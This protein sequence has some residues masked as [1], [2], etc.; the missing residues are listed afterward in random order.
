MTLPPLRLKKNEDRRLRAGHLW[1]FSNEVDTGKTPLTAFEAGQLIEIQ[2]CR[3]EVIG[4]GYVNPHSLICARLVSRDP[5]RVLNKSLLVHR[6]NMALSLREALFDKPYYRLAFGDSDGLPG[7]V[8]DRFGDVLVAQITTAGMEQCKDEVVAALDQAI[9]PSCIVL[10]NDT[11]SR[12][13]EGLD[14]YVETVLGTAPETVTLEENG[15]QF[16]APLLAG[17]K[18]GWFYDHRL[19]RARMQQYVRGKR[20]LDVFSYIGGWGVQAAAAGAS[21]VACVDSSEAALAAAQHNAALNGVAE[22]VKGMHGDAFEVLKALRAER[23]KFDVVILDP[24]A[25][26]KCKKDM[27]AGLEAYQRLNQQAM[28]VLGKDGIIISASCSFHLPR[29]ALMDAMLRA[30]RHID[31]NL[32]IIEQGHQGPDHPVHPAIPETNYL[33][34]FIGRVLPSA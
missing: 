1:V 30:S 21:E 32:Q 22:R 10:R 4:N 28:Q 12:A 25:F 33:K 7:L 24:P 13:M 6:L 26:I 29:P 8:V 14:S 9:K 5:E 19:N 11:S 23:E 16:V 34:A 20:V 27:R 17:Q 31:R 15:V 18:T 3:G 2:D